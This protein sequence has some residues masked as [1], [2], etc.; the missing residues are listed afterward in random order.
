MVGVVQPG[1]AAANAL[2]A[3]GL[4][5]SAEGGGFRDTLVVVSRIDE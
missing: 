5:D 2:T 3:G 1:R 4:N